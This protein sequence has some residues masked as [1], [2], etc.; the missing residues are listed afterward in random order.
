MDITLY[1]KF[2]IDHIQLTNVKEKDENLMYFNIKPLLIQTPKILYKNKKIILNPQ[3]NNQQKL[4]QFYQVIQNIE[5]K[6]SQIITD[7]LNKISP[8]IVSKYLL[9]P[10]VQL[11]KNIQENIYI[12]IT[13]IDMD[14]LY[15]EQKDQI[16]KIPQQNQE[17]EGA[18]GIFVLYSDKIAITPTYAKIS[19]KIV[20]S[21]FYTKQEQEQEQGKEK[22]K[23]FMINEEKNTKKNNNFSFKQLGI[24]KNKKNKKNKDEI[25]I[26]I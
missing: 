25:K 11:P 26:K 4:N 5:T 20:Q 23:K 3:V 16:H 21:M 18:Q 10:I 13:D 14:E 24:V 6:L 1:S 9:Q 12:P 2:N 15:D 17:G 7:E 8:D 22:E 19:W